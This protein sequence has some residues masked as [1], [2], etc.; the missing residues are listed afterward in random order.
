MRYFG[1]FQSSSAVWE[2]IKTVN[3]VFGLYSC[4]H[5]FPQDFGKFRPC[6]NYHIGKCTGVCK[7]TVTEAEYKKNIEQAISF[8]GGDYRELLSTLE[9]E[10]NQHSENLEFEKAALLRDRINNIKRL[11]SKQII[12]FNSNVERDI[13]AYSTL[14]NEVCFSVMHI[15]AGKLIF[16]DTLLLFLCFCHKI[17]YMH[18]CRVVFRIVL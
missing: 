14:E 3:E 5:K 10:M 17:R 13:I 1:P 12:V 11:E 4:K 2:I 15:R 16:Q 18:L 6:L 9:K 8:L 7:G